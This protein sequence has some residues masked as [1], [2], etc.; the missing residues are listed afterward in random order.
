M[1]RHL[2]AAQVQAALGPFTRLD[3]LGDPS[4]SGECWRA[5]K[6]GQDIAIKVIVREHEPGRFDREVRALER[7]ESDRVMKVTE[8]GTTDIAGREFPF[9]ISEFIPGSDVRRALNEGVPTD[10]ELRAFVLGCLEGVAELHA[11]G[12]VHRDIKPS[13]IMLRDEDWGD[14]VIIDLGLCRLVDSSFTV[15]PWAGGTWPYMAPEQLRAERT[16]DRTDVWSV[17]VT[18][19][20]VAAGSHPFKAGEAAMP[21]DWMSRLAR[22]IPPPGG[23]PYAF[24]EFLSHAGAFAAYKRPKAGTAH[25]ELAEKW[26]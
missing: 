10:I 3:E 15:Y 26:Q 5:Q 19:A 16:F 24:A 7:I 14:P 25:R 1:T 11:A 13:N 21:G 2:S 6:N 20:E 17:A 9:L 4:G 23:R 18:T 8:S 22:G 12:V